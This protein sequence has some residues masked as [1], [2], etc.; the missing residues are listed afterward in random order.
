[1]DFVSRC[2]AE[3]YATLHNTHKKRMHFNQQSHA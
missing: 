3:M 1:M 2:L